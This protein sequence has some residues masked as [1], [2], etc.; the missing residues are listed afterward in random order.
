MS[1]YK[2]KSEAKDF[3]DNFSKRMKECYRRERQLEY[4]RDKAYYTRGN[5]RYN[6]PLST[7]LREEEISNN[8]DDE[9]GQSSRFISDN[10]NAAQM[11]VDV[12][13]DVMSRTRERHRQKLREAIKKI[14]KECPKALYTFLLILKNGKNRKESICTI[15]E[16]I[17]RYGAKQHA[18]MRSIWRAVKGYLVSQNKKN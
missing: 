3:E 11:M 8:P 5:G 9:A 10:E 1:K 18:S 15:A 2:Y 4:W 16:R 14:Q 12:L 13:D 17:K 7:I 6:L